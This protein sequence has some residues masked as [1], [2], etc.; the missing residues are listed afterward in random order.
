M[1]E[2]E[3]YDKVKAIDA[4]SSAND[5]SR[6]RR[7]ENTSPSGETFYIFTEVAYRNGQA[8]LMIEPIPQNGESYMLCLNPQEA[9]A[10]SQKKN[11]PKGIS[12]DPRKFPDE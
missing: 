6:A 3:K 12:Y 7:K 5:V 10:I 1:Q 8:R 2:I 4:Y 9:L 11:R